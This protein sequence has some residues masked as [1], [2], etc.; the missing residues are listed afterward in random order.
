MRR[1]NEHMTRP[2]FNQSG[3]LSNSQDGCQT[4]S[5]RY[6]DL[7]FIHGV[8]YFLDDFIY[9]VVLWF[10]LSVYSKIFFIS[11]CKKFVIPL[12]VGPSYIFYAHRS[13]MFTIDQARSSEP[14]GVE[15]LI[16]YSH[17][18][19]DSEHCTDWK[20]STKIVAE[21]I[22]YNATIWEITRN[23]KLILENRVAT[24]HGRE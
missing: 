14:M 18:G 13:A 6:D 3:L 19:L 21:I 16:Y 7:L 10:R 5:R 2:Q 22:D 12:V 23:P 20:L 24:P 4:N 8:N 9:V 15:T 1:M 17:C 11:R